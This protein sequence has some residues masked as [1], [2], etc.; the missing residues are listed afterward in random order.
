MVMFGMLLE[1]WVDGGW[2]YVRRS[3]VGTM[4]IYD[5]SCPAEASLRCGSCP[6][7]KTGLVDCPVGPCSSMFM[8]LSTE[9]LNVGTSMF[10]S[11]W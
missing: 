8:S 9:L 2:I 11:R 6:R 5:V 1:Y 7:Q 10:R 4:W 3:V